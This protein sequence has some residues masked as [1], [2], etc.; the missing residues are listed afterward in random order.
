M[1]LKNKL[2]WGFILPI[3]IFVS[4]IIYISINVSHLQDISQKIAKEDLIFAE[5]TQSMKFEMVQVQ[6]WLTD[7]SATRGAKG[8][9]DGPQK[10][11]EYYEKFKKHIEEF[12][13]HYK[14]KHDLKRLEKVNQIEI[15]FENYYKVGKEMSELYVKGGPAAG[16]AFMANF[17]KAAEELATSID[18]FIEEQI[19]TMHTSIDQSDKNIRHMF[20]IIKIALGLALV[21]ASFVIF[22]LLKA[23]DKINSQFS[24]IGRFA[25]DLK[26][27]NLLAKVNIE[28]SNE[29]GVLAKSFN[30]SM[31]FIHNAFMADK[32]EWSELAKQKE[33]ELKA[34]EEAEV[35][36]AL[37]EKEKQQALIAKQNAE[38]EKMRA[39]KAV[40]EAQFEKQRA[41]EL[42]Q[43]E[44]EN[45]IILQNKVD[46]ILRVVSAAQNGDL[47]QTIDVT[48]NDAIGL[49]G[50]GLKEFFGQLKEDFT[51]INQ[52]ARDL[53]S[54]ANTIS[55]SSKLLSDNS[56]TTMTATEAMKKS[57]TDVSQNINYLNTSTSELKQA[58]SEISRQAIESNRF[59]T[60]AIDY[61]NQVENVSI[62]LDAN[63]DDISKYLIVISN[64]ARQTNLLAL[65][66]T[67]EAARAGEAGKG[68]AVVANEVKELARQSAEASEEITQK[69][70]IIK[71]NSTEIVDSVKKVSKCME[72][73][74]NSSRIVAA[75]TEEQFATTDKFVD[76][77]SHTVKEVDNV[78][79]RAN[80]VG[81][82]TE[83]TSEIIY[84]NSTI[85]NELSI[86]SDNL[87]NIVR[88]FKLVNQN[89]NL[90]KAA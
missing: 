69:V 73:I 44:K 67:I 42:S 13:T 86:T 39:E 10:A 45:S 66:A 77:I 89:T 75:A 19:T 26:D 57:T 54:Q 61:V 25:N 58:V 4:A 62:K 2:L 28:A 48:G 84:K 78:S 23:I 71:S 55:N 38:V 8:F 36:L 29:V 64:I 31:E 7:I 59:A 56:K 87:T 15:K 74:N 53:E 83:N 85:S 21:I 52:F 70:Q 40:E 20:N 22:N 51:V 11:A 65:N 5:A 37:A 6:Q 3:T 88:K 50:Q 17:D 81:A 27:G 82:V 18:P 72:D 1:T 43:K 9:D 24:E 16:N 76:L 90:K 33:N 80:N 79:T 35:A 68:F 30:S 46:K 49:M 32:I 60:S 63:T 47:T 14:L 12:K 41:E 34:K